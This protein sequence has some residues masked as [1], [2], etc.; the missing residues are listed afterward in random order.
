[1]WLTIILIFIILACLFFI[2]K[3]I[4][5]KFPL[6]ANINLL[7][8]KAER[9]ARVKSALLEKHFQRNFDF[10]KKIFHAPGWHKFFFFFAK[11]YKNL[12]LAEKKYY[13]NRRAKKFL[14]L[15]PT[16]RTDKIRQKNS[17]AE[18]LMQ[19]EDWPAAEKI[20]LEILALDLNHI[21]AYLGL[22]KI[23]QAQKDYL[24]AQE[25][26]QHV[27]KIDEKNDRAF[28]G[29]ADLSMATENWQAAKNNFQK[30]IELS[31]KNPE[32]YLDLA[33]VEYKLG[34]PARALTAIRRASELEP[35]NP[36]YIDFLIEAA[37]INKNKILALDAYNKLK[38]I[39]PENQKLP[40]FKKRIQEI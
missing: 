39:N 26:Y 1:M 27:L 18:E 3:I 35:N 5:P 29:L 15:D 9:Q 22:A 21:G 14:T 24:H 37:I 28:S 8:L 31:Q 40:E 11:I 13:E 20:Y 33:A 32:Y 38:K 10:L 6:L 30:S 19:K 7:E 16:E 34:N 12:H 23:Y 4:W 36:K 17:Q 2:A 25:L